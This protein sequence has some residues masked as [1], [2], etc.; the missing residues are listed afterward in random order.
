MSD[1]RQ[2][3]EERLTS[4]LSLH[5]CGILHAHEGQYEEAAG[6][7]LQAIEAEPEMVGSYVELGLV[8]AC[9]GE[10]PKMVESLRQAVEAGPG[11]VRAYLG[12]QPLGDVADAPKPPSYGHTRRGGGGKSDVVTP[13]VAAVS[14]LAEGRD[15]EAARMLE[16]ALEG[17]PTS[18]PP[19]VALL[20]LTY[21]LRGE[22]VEAD[23]AGI[24][25]AAAAAEGRARRC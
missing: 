1:V 23:E 19:L 24:R 16:E 17:K 2:V 5:L 8:Y 15:E 18:P 4:A 21:L 25:R 11:G 6:A 10:Y 12:R 20:A 7:F 13:L 9:R 22:G 14:Y 3:R